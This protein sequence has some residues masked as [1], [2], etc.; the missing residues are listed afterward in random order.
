MGLSQPELVFHSLRHG[1][2]YLHDL[3]CPQDIVE[4]LTGHAASSVHNKYAHRELTKLS[5]LQERLEKMQ[6]PDVVKAL[7]K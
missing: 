7:E 1:I 2:H 6:F 4:V 5:R 3:G